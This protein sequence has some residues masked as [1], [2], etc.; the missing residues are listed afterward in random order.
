MFKPQIKT[1]ATYMRGGDCG[2]SALRLVAAEKV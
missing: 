1:P 2:L